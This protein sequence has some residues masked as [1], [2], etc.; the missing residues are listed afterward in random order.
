M[1]YLDN[2]ASSYPKPKCVYAAMNNWVINNGANA[3]RSGHKL[4]YKASMMIYETRELICD[5]FGVSNPENISFVPNATYG[6]NM[7]IQGLLDEG[8]HVITTNLEHN[9]VLRPL[10]K[11]QEKNVSLSIADVDLTDDSKTIENILSLIK[12]NTKMIVC[13]QCSNVCGKVMPIKQLSRLKPKNVKLLVDGSQGAGVIPIDLEKDGV[14]YYCA[15][16][17]KSLYGPQGAGFVAVCSTP[18]K[19]IFCGG[20]GSDSFNKF[21]PDAMPDLLEC[22]TLPTPVIAGFKKGLEFINRIGVNNIYEHKKDQIYYI[23]KM[24]DQVNGIIKYTDTSLGEFVGAIS[25]NVFK[26][27]SEKLASYLADCDVCVRGGIHCAPQFHLKMNTENQG[28]V[29]VSPG[30]FNTKS[31]IN[32]LIKILNNYKNL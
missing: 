16:S 18:P 30:L 10:Y 4:S 1:I 31:H 24:L 27:N 13:T 3:G 25:F 9:S 12:R 11:C 22:G 26:Y 20:T 7:L 19:A 6:L 5:I 8:D 15:P 29:R 28:M 23:D 21:Q 17:H 2:A 32:Q 14:D